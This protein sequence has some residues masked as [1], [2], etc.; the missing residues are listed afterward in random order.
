MFV[1][2]LGVNPVLS[3][4]QAANRV[5]EV[6]DGKVESTGTLVPFPSAE[7]FQPANL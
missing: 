3:G 2:K 6:E 5:T 7:V 4:S 1:L